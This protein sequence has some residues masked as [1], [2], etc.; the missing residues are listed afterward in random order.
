[1]LTAI[2][3]CFEN[4]IQ[5]SIEFLAACEQNREDDDLYQ[6]GKSYYEFRKQFRDEHPDFNKYGWYY[7]D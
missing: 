2:K 4:D 1:M 7:I 3:A 6:G 5:E